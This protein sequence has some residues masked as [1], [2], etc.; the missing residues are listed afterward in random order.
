LVVFKVVVLNDDAKLY[1]MQKPI[2]Y[3]MIL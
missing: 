3:E 1:Q 2:L